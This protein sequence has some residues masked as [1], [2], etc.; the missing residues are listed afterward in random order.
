MRITEVITYWKMLFKF[1]QLTAAFFK[2]IEENLREEF[3]PGYRSLE[4]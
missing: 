1:F 2:E 3:I 4:D